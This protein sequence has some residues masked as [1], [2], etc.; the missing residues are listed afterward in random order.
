ASAVGH[1]DAGYLL[2]P[3]GE[4][5]IPPELVAEDDVVVL[6]ALEPPAHGALVGAHG[7]VPA[8]TAPLDEVGSRQSLGRR[9]CNRRDDLVAPSP[10]EADDP[11]GLRHVDGAAGLV[12]REERRAAEDARW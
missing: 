10:L 12:E 8:V 9:R 4:G 6:G 2:E 3:H 11:P 1:A 5:R 7:D